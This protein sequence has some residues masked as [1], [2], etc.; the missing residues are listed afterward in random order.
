MDMV[1][2][3]NKLLVGIGLQCFDG[4]WIGEEFKEPDVSDAVVV[5]VLDD[6]GGTVDHHLAE[7]VASVF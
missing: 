6:H 5:E 2:F 1:E 7:V 3:L 4:L